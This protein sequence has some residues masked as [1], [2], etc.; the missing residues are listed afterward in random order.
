MINLTPV[1]GIP[2]ELSHYRRD[3][4]MKMR[5]FRMN[6]AWQIGKTKVMTHLVTRDQVEYPRKISPICQYAKLPTIFKE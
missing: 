3:E 5:G 6:A 2:E 1:D 4:R